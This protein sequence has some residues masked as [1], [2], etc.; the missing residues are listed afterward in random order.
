MLVKALAFWLCSFVCVCFSALAAPTGPTRIENEKM[1]NLVPARLEVSIVSSARLKELV[2]NE[3]LVAFK[4]Q[5]HR[6][7]SNE[8]ASRL[9]RFCKVHTNPAQVASLSEGQRLAGALIIGKPNLTHHMT[10]LF[11][12]D[13]ETSISCLS[14]EDQKAMT[15]R[16]AENDLAGIVKF[17]YRDELGSL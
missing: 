9:T 6:I 3:N 1:S 13:G 5:L 7:D 11:L 2:E 10:L 8:S 17:N 4:G 16:D 14:F 15:L 12:N